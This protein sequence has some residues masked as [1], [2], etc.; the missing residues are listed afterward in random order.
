VYVTVLKEVLEQ[1]GITVAGKPVDCD[2]VAG[3]SHKPADFPRLIVQQSPPL[4]DVGKTLMKR[5]QNLYAETFAHAM[6]RQ[7]SGRGSFSEGRKVVQERLKGFGI[8]PDTYAYM[9]GS[10]LSRY[11]LISPRQL[12][13][14]LRGMRQSP[15]WE[16]WREMLPIA[17]VDGTLGKRMKGT[18]AEGNVRAKTGTVSNVRALSGYVHT[19]DGEELLFSFIVNSHLRSDRDTEAVTDGV[20]TQL[21]GFDGRP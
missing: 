12:V 21:A 1:E 17:G 13:A 7:R 9:D 10:G 20:L 5:S 14:I 6:G 19:A 3:W 15:N 18:P 4:S 11:D 2:S 8:E 16:V